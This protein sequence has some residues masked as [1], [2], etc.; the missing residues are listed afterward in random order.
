MIRYSTGPPNPRRQLLYQPIK[1]LLM[2]ASRRPVPHRK[3]F[4]PNAP[5][6]IGTVYR[7]DRNP[8]DVW[9]TQ[10]LS[11]AEAKADQTTDGTEYTDG[12]C[13][14]LIGA[15]SWFDGRLP[16]LRSGVGNDRL[17][18]E[19]QRGGLLPRGVFGGQKPLIA[20]RAVW[21]DVAA[22]LGSC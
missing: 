13:R 1:L 22:S 10:Q 16:A 19:L 17:K 11:V 15:A 12:S 8:H 4:Q 7:R 6:A 21:T 20:Q 14:N 18:A 9:Q 2:R 5:Q 3:H